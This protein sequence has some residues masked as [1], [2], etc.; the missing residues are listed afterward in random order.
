MEKIK[1][2]IKEGMKKMRRNNQELK[3]EIKDLQISR[4]LKAKMG[5]EKKK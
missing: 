3:E 1:N 5:M 4:E 2:L